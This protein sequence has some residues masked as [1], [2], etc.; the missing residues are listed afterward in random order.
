M[1][2]IIPTQTA[3]L[4]IDVQTGLFCVD[5]APFEAEAV[6]A[7]INAVTAAARQA[8]SPVIFIQHDGEPGGEDVVPFTEGWKLHP[9]LEVCPGELVIRKTTCDAFYGTPLEAELRSRGISTL[10]LMG[11]ATERPDA[12]RLPFSSGCGSILTHPLKEGEKENPQAILGMFDVSA[13]PFVEPN[14][15]TLAMPTKLFLTLLA[16]QDESFLITKSWELVRK[17]I[18]KQ[19]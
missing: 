11:Y 19:R 4:V 14:I 3:V 1:N 16:N 15:L 10:V 6:V 8:G 5:P 12:V 17:R 7:R 2:P 18:E 9:K 13:R